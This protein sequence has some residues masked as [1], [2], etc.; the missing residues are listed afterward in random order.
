[1]LRIFNHSGKD[2]RAAKNTARKI[3][4]PKEFSVGG[5]WDVILPR[6]A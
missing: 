3:S 1:M 6:K 2:K 4:R 5:I